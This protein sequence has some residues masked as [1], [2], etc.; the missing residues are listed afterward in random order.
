MTTESPNPMSLPER[1]GRLVWL[2]NSLRGFEELVAEHRHRNS[3]S[4]TRGDSRSVSASPASC[5][6]RQFSQSQLV[7]NDAIPGISLVTPDHSCWSDVAFQFR[8]GRQQGVA[9]GRLFVFQHRGEIDGLPS[10][11]APVCVAELDAGQSWWQ[12][13]AEFVLRP[14][15]WYWFL[16]ETAMPFAIGCG[17]V[18]SQL[19][20]AEGPGQQFRS[21]SGFSPLFCLRGTPLQP[22]PESSQRDVVPVA[23]TVTD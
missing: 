2:G 23:V 22:V 13:P 9:Q 18:A 7:V 5:T 8:V 14:A 17:S 11:A 20:A 19:L 21:F 4:P 12:F 1:S 3:G 15:M 16:A 6:I 10:A